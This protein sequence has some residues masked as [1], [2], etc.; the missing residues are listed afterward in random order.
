MVADHAAAG[1]RDRDDI[2]ENVFK[3]LGRHQIRNKAR[4][5]AF[6]GR[7]SLTIRVCRNTRPRNIAAVPEMKMNVDGAGESHE[8]ACGNFRL[9]R[10]FFSGRRDRR[11]AAVTNR[12]IA[13]RPAAAG[14]MASAFRTTRSKSDM[15]LTPA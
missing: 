1:L 5:T 4:D 8:A 6:R 14:S 7:G 13:G 2:I 15:K 11:N 3:R 12:N 10:Q 9:R